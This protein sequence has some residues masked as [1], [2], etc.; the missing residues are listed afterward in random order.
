MKGE[1]FD[2]RKGPDHLVAGF[3]AMVAGKYQVNRQEAESELHMNQF[4]YLNQV[5]KSE[6]EKPTAREI[7][8]AREAARELAYA[9]PLNPG[10]MGCVQ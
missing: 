6:V 10:S 9:R 1:P 3:P 4:S 5:Y 2:P 7:D 8:S